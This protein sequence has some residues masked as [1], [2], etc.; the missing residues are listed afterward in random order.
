[1]SGIFGILNLDGQPVAPELL[2][3]M[4]DRFAG[5]GPHGAGVW[6]EGDIGLG[7]LLSYNTPESR[8]ECLP[9]A[10][11]ATGVVLTAHARLDNRDQLLAD[12][13][14][15]FTNGVSP[16]AIPDGELILGAY[17]TWG[18][19]CVEHLLGDWAFA[20]WDPR[21]RKFFLAR[22]H[23]GISAV[24][25]YQQSCC[26]A[27]A[28]S[29]KGL[30]ALPYVPQ[31]PN[32]VRVAQVLTSWPGDGAQTGY[33]GIFRLPPAH[34]LT[35]ANGRVAIRRY[36]QL[37]NL[38]P[39]RFNSDAQ[40]VEAFLEIYATAVR[41]R[42]R[43]ERPVG[44]TLSSG[45][46]SGSV[47]ALAARELRVH[48]Q[49]LPV[50]TSVPIHPTEHVTG[51]GL[52][53]DESS[54]VETD[55]QFIDNLDLSFIRAEDVSPLGGIECDLNVHDEPGHAASNTFW[56][57][58][59]LQAARQRGLAVLLTGQVGNGTISWTG[60]AENLWPLILRGRWRTTWSN[61]H[62][63]EPSL[64]RIMKHQLLAPMIRPLRSRIKR[65]RT[66]GREPWEAY[67]AINAEF[68]RSLN[69]TARMVAAG[70]DPWFK[71]L[72]DPVQARLHIIQI[73][74][75]LAGVLWAENGAAYGLEV[76]DPTMDK[77]LIE[78]C[79][80]IP[81][82]QYRGQGYDRWLI[83]R[84]MA[85]LL[86]DAVRLNRRR[87]LQAADL[88]YRVLDTLPEVQSMMARLEHSELA[89]EVLD[90]AKMNS[91]LQALQREVNATTTGQCVTI[92]LRGMMVGMFL[93]R[94]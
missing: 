68:A 15:P 38:A 41:C 64:W 72:A 47:C 56:I 39:I 67:A 8:H 89:R 6:S 3:A 4:R 20:L 75:N 18:E 34:M 94:F 44:A 92:L 11:G 60:T 21:E 79:L 36:W 86:P 17:L 80:A 23:Q 55:R 90:L 37:D 81:D 43:S 25:Y 24:Y 50:F 13:R 87:G 58:A 16:A 31:R 71:A 46:D 69:L 48:G 42:L 76:R 45:L 83:R 62:A 33:E 26:F 35:I 5:W 12:S 9:H 29:I 57:T 14:W 27:F 85:G 30:F 28:S 91:V 2:H 7:H 22:D 1:M 19:Q 70:H 77:R 10:D 49:R 82:E 63:L 54:L 32:L 78:F 65:Y 61:A 74:T 84:A 40:Y 66:G 93:L 73:S 53:G 88:G 51:R 52:Y 59:L